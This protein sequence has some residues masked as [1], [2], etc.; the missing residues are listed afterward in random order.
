MG[1]PA[2]KALIPENFSRF[3]SLAMQLAGAPSKHAS[4]RLLAEDALMFRRNNRLRNVYGM[5]LTVRVTTAA[6]LLELSFTAYLTVY[7]PTAAVFT[8][9]VAT[10]FAVMSP[11]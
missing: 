11:S 6:E 2:G 1:Y 10:V 4:G 3:R 9:L 7:V 8:V 5:T